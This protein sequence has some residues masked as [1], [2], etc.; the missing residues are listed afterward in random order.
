MVGDAPAGGIG[1]GMGSGRLTGRHDP[2]DGAP[3]R[4][5]ASRSSLRNS[6]RRPIRRPSASPRPAL[7]AKAGLSSTERVPGCQRQKAPSAARSPGSSPARRE[8]AAGPLGVAQRELEGVKLGVGKRAD[9]EM[10]GAELVQRVQGRIV[11]ARQQDEQGGGIGLDR[12]GDRPNRLLPLLER[13]AR[14]D[15]GDR[16]A[17]GDEARLGIVGTARGDRL[18][19]GA[20][21]K[22]G[23]LVAMAKGEDEQR[24]RH[25]LVAGAV[26]RANRSWGRLPA[27]AHDVAASC[28]SEAYDDANRKGH[29]AGRLERRSGARGR[30]DAARALRLRRARR[31]RADRRPRRRR[32]PAPPCTKCWAAAASARCSA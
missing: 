23:Q 31:G 2:L 20:L 11:V 10:G 16:G 7:R 17:R 30:G 3:R 1:V 5:A 22:P 27:L 26:A 18:P 4:A 9:Q 24:R 12:V 14:V 29:G 28:A 21:G 15:D 19:A 13:A 6:S 32:L 25:P 8:H